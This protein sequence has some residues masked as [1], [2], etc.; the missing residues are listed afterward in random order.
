[1]FFQE[2]T[3]HWTMAMGRFADRFI[4][5]AFYL[6]AGREPPGDWETTLN[7]IDDWICII[8][9]RSTIL[10]S[11]MVVEQKFNTPVRKAVGRQCCSLVHHKGTPVDQ[12]PLPRM[13]DTG[14][15]ESAEMELDNGTWVLVT[16]DPIRDARGDICGAVHITRDITRR[17]LVQNERK[18]LVKEL[19]QALTRIKTLSGLIPICASCKKIRDDKGYWNLIESYIES[20]SHASF[21]H[22]ICPE[23]MDEIY[24]HE[25]WY[26]ELKQRKGWMGKCPGNE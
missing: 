10:R 8:D 22:S 3:S 2:I 6:P 25:S 13:L 16:V 1:M 24:G 7:A 4:K 19:K 18:I 9:T 12:C 11:N 20:H 17:V 26:H 14:K 5:K 21:S 15:R 23:C